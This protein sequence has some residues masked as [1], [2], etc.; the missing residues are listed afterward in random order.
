M[1]RQR[2]EPRRL[3]RTQWQRYEKVGLKP[4]LELDDLVLNWVDWNINDLDAKGALVSLTMERTIEGAS[5]VTMT[6]RDPDGRVAGPRAE[7]G[8]RLLI[9]HKRGPLYKQ[10][11]VQVDEG[12][13]A[14]LAPV[15][16]GRAMEVELDGVVF[17]LVKVRYTHSTTELEL[18]FED[19]IVY[20]L[21]RKRGPKRANRAK[22]TR[23]E[24]VLSLL[25]E[26][27]ARNY[28]FVCPEL[29]STQR[30]DKPKGKA[31]R[32]AEGW[33]RT[34]LMRSS[35]AAASS[36]DADGSE[37][38]FAPSHKL[39]VKGAKAT[40]AQRRRMV[41]ILNEARRLGASNLVMAACIACATQES[42]MGAS[43]G[44]TGNDD[45]GLYQQGR[46]WISARDAMDPAKS[47]RAFLTGAINGG[48][49]KGWQDLHGSLTRAPGGFE[50]A[51]KKVQVS[52]GGYRQW[53]AEA[54]RTVAQF[55]GG[56]AGAGGASWSTKRYQF[57]RNSDED[58]WSAMQRLGQEVGWRCFVVG[59][60]V[61]Y[62]SEQ[63]LYA[64]R[65]RYEVRPD[66]PAVL[67]FTCDLDWGKPV[68]EASMTVVL[69]RWGAP[70]GS[71][72][73]AD[74][75]GPPD[76]RWLVVSVSRDWFSPTAEVRLKQ[77]GRQLLEPANERVQRAN[78]ASAAG[79]Q[80]EGGDSSKAGQVYD[81]AR[82]I[83][84][85]NYPYVW[86]GGHG[87]AG[88]P[89]GGGYDCSGSVCAALAAA[90]LG[91]HPGG[92][93]DVSG[94]MASSWGE[95]G[96]GRHFTVWA[97]G[98]HVWMQ[99]HGMGAWRFDTSPYGSGGRGP[100]LRSAP[101]PTS[102]FTARHWPGC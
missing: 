85:R 56:G 17:R 76:G 21:K 93:V 49:A 23:A 50:N 59:N 75:F 26:V 37:G 96:E 89:S 61:Y 30:V 72:V 22:V 46:N 12:W 11:P 73:V 34:G 31:V 8:G 2:T 1:P 69:D 101:R 88:K 10:Y 71:V 67:E 7:R 57:S 68:S 35:S 15:Q 51:I 54:K 39:T 65:P 60:S 38:G 86:G 80:G 28:R 64:R 52:V 44:T 82:R 9:R 48:G 63:Q 78:N 29:H 4:T 13:D 62:M 74:G 27:K 81:A 20:W 3:T 90:G 55:Q 97:N 70:P 102:G 79:P 98:G 19:R 42:V 5:T 6:L 66:S 43:A 99:F 91:Y 36:D 94:T 53:E 24:F 100:H 47:T 83:D 58:S 32:H 40:P 95:P 87:A 25:R 45:T 92:K 84:S 41:G 33:T 14:I 18:T 16:M 77:P